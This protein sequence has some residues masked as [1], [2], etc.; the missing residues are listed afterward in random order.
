MGDGTVSLGML[1]GGRDC[2]SEHALWETWEIGS[3]SRHMIWY[4]EYYLVGCIFLEI[5]DIPYFVEITEIMEISDTSE[6]T[7]ITK[8]TEMSATPEITEISRASGDRSDISDF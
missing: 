6:I 8:I 1:S 7:E 3:Y 2:Q 5:P 4:T